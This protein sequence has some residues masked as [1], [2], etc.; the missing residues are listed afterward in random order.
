MK[1]QRGVGGGGGGARLTRELSDTLLGL[2][3]EPKIPD[4]SHTF[5]GTYRRGKNGSNAEIRVGFDRSSSKIGDLILCAIANRD[6]SGDGAL[7]YVL[8]KGLFPEVEIA[9]EVSERWAE[10]AYEFFGFLPN[11]N[12]VGYWTEEEEEDGEHFD[13]NDSDDNVKVAV[14]DMGDVTEWASEVGLTLR[15]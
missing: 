7:F 14:L 1:K 15:N 9:R 8:Y 12:D 3:K 13:D 6:A 11:E 5:T 10:E 2:R 4:V